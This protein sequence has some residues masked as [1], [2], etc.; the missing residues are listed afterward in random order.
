VS[1]SPS[2]CGSEGALASLGLVLQLA[3]CTGIIPGVAPHEIRYD[4]AALEHDRCDPTPVDPR[5]YGRDIIQKVEPFY[6][7]VM[8]GP[9]G[10]EAHLAGAQLELRPLPGITGELLERGLQCR[11]AQVMLG[12]VVAANSEPYALADRWVRIDVKSGGGSFIVTIAPEDGTRAHE[13]W[14]RARAFAGA[15][16]Q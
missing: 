13:V 15:G 8:G 9:N 3:G 4:A 16:A 14:D 1:F 5:I 6:R 12:H 11:S 2:S 10:K 7:Y